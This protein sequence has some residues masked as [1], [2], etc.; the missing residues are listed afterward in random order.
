MIKK[1]TY[2]ELEHKVKELENESSLRKNK[3]GELG[4][5][6]EH[7]SSI[8]HKIEA[9]VVVHDADTR[10]V[11]CNTKAKAELHPEIYDQ[12]KKRLHPPGSAKSGESSGA[13]PRAH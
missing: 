1:P 10:I 5:G 9:A 2:E 11:A 7:Y 8:I 4:N 3:E 13:P 6:E 12:L